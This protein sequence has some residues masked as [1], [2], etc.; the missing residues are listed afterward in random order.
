MSGADRKELKSFSRIRPLFSLLL[1]LLVVFGCKEKILHGLDEQKANRVR[2]LLA[3]AGVQTKKVRDGSGWDVS[4]SKSQVTLALSALQRGRFL[5]TSSLPPMS[6]NSLVQSREERGYFLERNIAANL[7][8]T[9]A[10]LPGV[11]EARVHIK[12]ARDNGMSLLPKA[13]RESASVLL[14]H[15]AG[16]EIDSSAVKNLVSGASGV[17]TDYVAIIAVAENSGTAIEGSPSVSN[18]SL[19]G[20]EELM[21]RN[22][23][24]A[25]RLIRHE[26]F[27]S[28]H[29][30]ESF[31][32]HIFWEKE[33]LLLAMLV[34]LLVLVIFSRTRRSQQAFLKRARQSGGLENAD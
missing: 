16:L 31:L 6:S 8:H 19:I 18:L 13:E 22:A 21:L 25:P 15:S 12:F 9:L 34:F 10:R 28:M 26:R 27:S 11:L 1:L 24:S 23:D 7:E 3:E 33:F 4:V 14:V 30:N 5:T 2:V 32:S 20:S 29:A 17:K